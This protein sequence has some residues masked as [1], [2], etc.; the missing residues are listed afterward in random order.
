VLDSTALAT[1]DHTGRLI[2]DQRVTPPDAD[3]GVERMA[4]AT[5]GDL[6]LVGA[7]SEDIDNV[8]FWFARLAPDGTVIASA[9]HDLQDVESATAVAPL[10]DG[11]A[12]VAGETVSFVNTPNDQDIWMAR[13]DA[14]GRMIGQLPGGLFGAD[15][16]IG[17]LD[18]SQERG[19]VM[20]GSRYMGDNQYNHVLAAGLPLDMIG[21]MRADAKSNAFYTGCIRSDTDETDRKEI[22]RRAKI[23]F[24]ELFEDDVAATD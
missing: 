24:P 3:Y 7:H 2:T 15:D 19:L 12:M 4:L 10:P 14:S 1:L 13:L 16:W 9:T 5:D 22:C 8:D 21:L 20:L 18:F 6:L 17:D 11:G 23:Y